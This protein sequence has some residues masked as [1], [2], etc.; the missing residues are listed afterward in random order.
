MEGGSMLVSFHLD[1][2]SQA[3]WTG[4]LQHRKRRGFEEGK[5]AGRVGQQ[6]EKQA[7]GPVPLHPGK[8]RKIPIL[9]IGRQRRSW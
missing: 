4:F 7:E 3:F 9:R 6:A 5:P 1:L 2:S 8:K